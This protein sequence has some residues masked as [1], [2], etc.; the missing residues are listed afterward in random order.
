[1]LPYVLHL[2]SREGPFH[3]VLW[4]LVLAAF[5]VTLNA[6]LH[7]PRTP[8]ARALLIPKLYTRLVGGNADCVANATR[9]RDQVPPG[10]LL[11]YPQWEELIGVVEPGLREA[12]NIKRALLQVLA[13]DG[14][15]SD[16]LSWGDLASVEQDTARLDPAQRGKWRLQVQLDA[17]RDAQ[18]RR[19]TRI[20]VHGD[21]W[22]L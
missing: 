5:A 21:G 17:W 18:S 10:C 8:A 11:S 2:Q 7:I 14:G 22:V 19:E 9:V 6:S 15:A 4:T 13:V 12:S 1:M 3:L 16:Q 20:P